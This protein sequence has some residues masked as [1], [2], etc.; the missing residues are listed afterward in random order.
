MIISSQNNLFVWQFPI[1]FLEDYLYDLFQDVLDKNFMPYDNALDFINSTIKEINFPGLT[2]EMAEQTK[3]KGKKIDWKATK[4]VFDT[5]NR[6]LDITFRSVESHINYFM[7]VQIMTE[8]YL[9]NDKE[10]LPIL[11]LHIL[12]K[13]GDLMYTVLFKDVLLKGL[14]DI[15][16]SYASYDVQEKTFTLSIRYV[17][18][19]ILWET[20]RH[21]LDPD[22]SIFQ[23]PKYQCGD[24]DFNI[25]TY[26]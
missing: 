9:N 13:T 15:R 16:L 7:M 8:F 1:D 17:W 12:D 19:D 24:K 6:D 20:K 22:R 18:M 2:Y 4:N 25:G 26:L 21:P 14:S 11:S 23:L 10:Y 5:F 3:W